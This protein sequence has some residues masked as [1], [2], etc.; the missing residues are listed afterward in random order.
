MKGRILNAYSNLS[1]EIIK[2]ALRL[3]ICRVYIQ[4]DIHTQLL[5]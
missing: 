1:Q 5:F 4:R 3:F 2:K